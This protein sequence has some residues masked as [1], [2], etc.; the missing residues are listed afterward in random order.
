[1]AT[2][3][4][5]HTAVHTSIKAQIG[6]WV[7]FVRCQWHVGHWEVGTV[8]STSPERTQ[9]QRDKGTLQVDTARER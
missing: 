3:A 6:G 9:I 8:M 2:S 1:M 4:V 5:T 7:C